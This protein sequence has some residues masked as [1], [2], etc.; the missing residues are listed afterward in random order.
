MT[1][2]GV[3]AGTVS[4]VVHLIVFLIGL[5]FFLGSLVIGS[6][7]M[8]MMGI[9]MFVIGVLLMRWGQGEDG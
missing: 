7:P 1:P 8:L 9:G 4:T 5:A 6:G 3:S 2:K